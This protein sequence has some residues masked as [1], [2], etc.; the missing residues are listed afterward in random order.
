MRA[1][2]SYYDSQRFGRIATL[3]LLL[4]IPVA[5]VGAQVS[6]AYTQ[7]LPTGERL[8]PIGDFV[9]LGS[10]P[11]AMTLAPGED[12]LAVVLSGWRE[13]GL[14]IVDLRSRRVL[15]TLAQPSAFLGIAFS[16]DGK[17]LFVSGGNEDAV[18]RYSWQNGAAKFERQIV[19]AEKSA[20][21]P[22]TRYPA[23][24]GVSLLG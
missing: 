16:R 23:G 19:L 17:D 10:M 18:F 13:Q 11:V 8:D 7:P 15:Q 22:G 1:A 14:Q 9:D 2:K 5:Q 3:W 6:P 4:I 24:L 20:G 21:K 12:K